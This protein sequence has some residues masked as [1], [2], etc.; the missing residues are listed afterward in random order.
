MRTRIS[1]SCH[2]S[3][4][5]RRCGAIET[6]WRGEIVRLSKGDGERVAELGA[7]ESEPLFAKIVKASVGNC[8]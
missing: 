5:P 3:Q 4:N 8:F 2:F 7:V 1:C 6:P